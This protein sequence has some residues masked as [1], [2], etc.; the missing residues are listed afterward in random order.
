MHV[1]DQDETDLAPLHLTDLDLGAA[2]HLDVRVPAVVVQRRGP[3]G[4]PGLIVVPR[5]DPHLDAGGAEGLDY[6]LSDHLPEDGC[7]MRPVEQIPEDAEQRR[8]V[9][10]RPLRGLREVPMEIQR[11]FR[12]AGLRIDPEIE[13][14]ALVDVAHADDFV[15]PGLRK[16]PVLLIMST[17]RSAKVSNDCGSGWHRGRRTVIPSS[18]VGSTRTTRQPWPWSRRGRSPGGGRR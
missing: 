15:H 17:R 1:R 12:D 16:G 8:L 4:P 18:E 13:V 3:R 9:F 5:E 10:D 2:E 7:D 14:Q 6:V 11:A